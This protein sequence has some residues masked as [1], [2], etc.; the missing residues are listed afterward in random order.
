[1]LA[2]CGRCLQRD[3]DDSLQ[4]KG[5]AGEYWIV[6]MLSILSQ[7]SKPG[8]GDERVILKHYVLIRGEAATKEKFSRFYDLF[9]DVIERHRDVVSILE[10][11][12]EGRAEIGEEVVKLMVL[13]LERSPEVSSQIYDFQ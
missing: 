4:M 2:L 10:D 3:E 5:K 7:L 11:N 12:E 8:E 6:P 1:M 13:S 9:G